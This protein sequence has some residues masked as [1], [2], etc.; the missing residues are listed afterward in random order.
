LK[1]RK[2]V[3]HVKLPCDDSWDIQ[4]PELRDRYAG[5]LFDPVRMDQDVLDDQRRVLGSYKYAG[6]FGQDPRPREGGM[7]QKHWFEVVDAAPDGGIV[8]RG[9][10]LAASKKKQGAA[11]SAQAATS[12]VKI[13][14]VDPIVEDGMLIGGTVYILDDV[15]LF[16][17][18][19]QVRRAMRNT[20]KQDGDGCTHDF[21]QDPG[22]AGKDQARSL[23]ANLHGFRVRYSPESGDKVV[24]ADPVSAQ[25]EAGNVKLVKAPWNG[26]FLDEVTYFPNGRKDR[27]D[28]LGRAYRRA[29]KIAELAAKSAVGGPAG[30]RNT[31]NLNPDREAV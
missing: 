29:L 3:R 7:F 12:G 31:R 18:G 8:V 22:Q 5:G 9:W 19:N 10:D 28:A 11:G 14:L 26:D 30:T 23:A 20:A 16:G 1:R 15:N 2:N 13:K 27:V 21:P 17:T 25:V 4:P 24:R 6:Q